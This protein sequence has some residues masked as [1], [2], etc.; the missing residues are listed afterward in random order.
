M[1]YEKN[2]WASGDVVTSAKLNNIENGIASGGVLLCTVD[3][4]GALNHTWQEIYD[5]P[6][7]VLYAEPEIGHEVCFL[8]FVSNS[9][10]S[11]G[12]IKYNGE[13]LV[14]DTFVASSAD[15][16]PTSQEVD[17]GGGGGDGDG[18]GGK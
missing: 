14:Y 7:A 15:G 8:W 16:H 5:A 12:F 17:N 4:N 1:A 6:F 3:G 11:V 13:S 18:D 2:T 9:N 10:Y